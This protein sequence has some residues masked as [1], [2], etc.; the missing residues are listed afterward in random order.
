MSRQENEKP[1][2]SLIVPVYNVKSYLN[3]CIDSLIHQTYQ[4]VEI[5]LVDDG[6]TD[7]S[8]T[9]CDQY[10]NIDSR[11][12]VIHNTNAGL[13]YSRNNGLDICTGEYVSF[14]DS[15]DY[16]SCSFVEIL[17]ETIRKN[18]LSMCFSQ[19]QSF[20]DVK[21]AVQTGPNDDRTVHQ[22]SGEECIK[23]LLS[24]RKFCG[25]RVTGGLISNSCFFHKR[26][27][28][29]MMHEDTEITP[30]LYGDAEKIGYIRVPMYFQRLREG[31]L[32]RSKLSCRNL[33]L[34]TA[35]E[36]AIQY[37]LEKYPQYCYLAKNRL[38]GAALTLLI[39]YYNV[40]IPIQGFKERCL[41]TLQK[42][43][44]SPKIDMRYRITY[45]AVII[46]PHITAKIAAHVYHLD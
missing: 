2:V 5:I 10:S 12:T 21:P 38:I 35:Y 46:A 11:I 33:D 42:N 25:V 23:D 3:E 29:G 41:E 24:K 8:E 36:S 22:Y 32:T 15:D 4:N 44:H 34:I 27:K 13:S 20:T 39:R 45:Y 9:I 37:C 19:N 6:S 28:V 26:F 30:S 14:V 1:K 17:V 16:I 7:G 31:S 18:S 43:I 40:N